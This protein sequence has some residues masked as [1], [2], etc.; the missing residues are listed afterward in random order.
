MQLMTQDGN[1]VRV[2]GWGQS[3]VWWDK[4]FYYISFRTEKVTSCCFGKTFA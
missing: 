4:I 3:E 1:D 2:Y